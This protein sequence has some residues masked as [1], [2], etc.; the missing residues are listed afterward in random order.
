MI[1]TYLNPQND[2]VFK[3]VFGTEKNKDILIA[4][5]NEVIG[6]QLEGPIEEVTFLNPIQ[7]P[8]AAGSKQSLLD[9]LCKDNK[10]ISIRY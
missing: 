4:L 10:G 1:T 9:V 7:E 6:D 3:R 2:I 8:Y 5:L